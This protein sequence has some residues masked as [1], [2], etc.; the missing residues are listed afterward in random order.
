M[1][2]TP[3]AALI[4]NP[5]YKPIPN[6]SEVSECFTVPL[7]AFIS[8]E[9]HLSFDSLW[10]NRLYRVHHFVWKNQS[11]MG[12]SASICVEVAKIAFN[13]Q[14]VDWEEIIEGQPSRKEYIKF[15]LDDILTQNK[16]KL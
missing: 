10:N 7:R 3:V 15:M 5:F 9:Y 13:I 2:V 11:V 4:T 8:K 14:N 1:L 6:P 16:S 12:F